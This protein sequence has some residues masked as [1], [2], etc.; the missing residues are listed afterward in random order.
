LVITYEKALETKKVRQ[1]LETKSSHVW[2]T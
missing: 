1:I 2:E